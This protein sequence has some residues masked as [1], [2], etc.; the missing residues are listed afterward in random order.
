MKAPARPSKG[1]REPE[2]G[3]IDAKQ[4]ARVVSQGHGAG[5][6]MP[7]RAPAKGDAAGK[8]V[9]EDADLLGGWSAAETGRPVK[10]SLTIAGHRTAVSLEEPFWDGLRRA[11]S[12]RDLPIAR[13]VAAIDAARGKASLS[14]AIRVFVLDYHRRRGASA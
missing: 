11:A 2:A 14:S 1:K 4:Q 10:R 7:M 8:S 3:Q 5:N 12:D 9:K 13:L 6:S